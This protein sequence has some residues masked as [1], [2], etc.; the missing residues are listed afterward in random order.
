MQNNSIEND[1]VYRSLNEICL[2]KYELDSE[3]S[4]AENKISV[5][6]DGLFHKPKANITQTQRMSNIVNNGI[7]MLDG[8]ILGW[9]LYRRFTGGNCSISSNWLNFFLR[10]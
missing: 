8:L 5:L 10:K 7:G 6:W 2:R 1:S 4:K 3:I 9:K